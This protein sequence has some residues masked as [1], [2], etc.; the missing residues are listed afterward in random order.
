[1]KA[2]R[3]ADQVVDVRKTRGWDIAIHRPHR[4]G[5]PFVI[6]R[7][8]TRQE[9]IAKHRAWFQK[10]PELMRDVAELK[11]KVLGCKC[12]APK[13]RCHGETLL[14]LAEWPAHK[15]EVLRPVSLFPDAYLEM[16]GIKTRVETT[17]PASAE[18]KYRRPWVFLR[19]DRSIEP[20]RVW[21]F[22]DGSSSGWHA[23]KIVRPLI[24]VRSLCRYIVPTR[25]RNV[26]AE[27]NGFL[28]GLKNVEED[29]TVVVVVDFLNIAAWMTGAFAVNDEEVKS[30]IDRAKRIVK[31]NH[32]R[33]SFIHH[34]GH[35]RDDSMMTYFN[36]LADQLCSK[37]VSCDHTVPWE[38]IENDL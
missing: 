22:T 19:E 38:R 33:L 30:K 15:R 17:N 34:A 14:E 11:G 20:D 21:V 31:S 3:F 25:T 29:S 5:N 13:R 23:A 26:G 2:R 1:M 4:F 12:G 27:L 28:L 37:Q 9:V 7:D 8:G 6:G 24:D 18:R 35:Q 10:Q 32:L 16:P 36:D